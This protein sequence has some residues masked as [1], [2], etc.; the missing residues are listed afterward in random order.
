MATRIEKRV[1][2]L[3]RLS[4]RDGIGVAK[5]QRR[6]KKWKK[7]YDEILSERYDKLDDKRLL[8][9]ADRYKKTESKY[10]LYLEDYLKAKHEKEGV[11]K[12]DTQ[13]EIT[14]LSE[15]IEKLTNL[16]REQ[17]DTIT[18]P[19]IKKLILND[20][21]YL[22]KSLPKKIHNIS[23]LLK[24][25]SLWNEYIEREEA[26][27]IALLAIFDSIDL[28]L[29]V[30]A[31][32]NH[33]AKNTE[34]SLIR[35]TLSKKHDKSIF[36][37]NFIDDYF[38]N[39]TGIDDKRIT[40]K[41]VKSLE[42]YYT[43]PENKKIA[44]VSMMSS[45][46][47]KKRR[48][49]L[50]RT[51][52]FLGLQ[53]FAR[54]VLFTIGVVSLFVPFIQ[55]PALALI[56][57]SVGV[58]IFPVLTQFLIGKK[59][60]PDVDSNAEHFIEKSNE[61]IKIVEEGLKTELSK[62]DA[63][64]DNEL[65]IDSALDEKNEIKSTNTHDKP[66]DDTIEKPEKTKGI[67][68]SINRFLKSKL[69]SRAAYGIKKD[70]SNK[71]KWLSKNNEL[72]ESEYASLNDDS[73]L[74]II[75]D[76]KSLSSYYSEYYHSY[77]EAKISEENIDV[78]ID[79]QDNN[80]PQQV[81]INSNNQN[82]D[83]KEST[84]K[85]SLE[86]Q[87]I[88]HRLDEIKDP[89]V[90]KLIE[91]DLECLTNGLP[92]NVKDLR[93]LIENLSQWNEF[94]EREEAKDIAYLGIASLIELD[95]SVFATVKHEIKNTKV[96]LIRRI[97][98]KMSDKFLLLKK[99]HNLLNKSSKN[100]E[101][102]TIQ[103][104]DFL[105]SYYKNPDN[106]KSAILA[107]MATLNA[108]KEIKVL[109]RKGIFLALSKIVTPLLFV[110][111]I[112]AIFS[113]FPPLQIIGT[114]LTSIAVSRVFKI[115][116]I[117]LQFRIG[118]KVLPSV[119]H[120]IVQSSIKHREETKKLEETTEI[121]LDEIRGYSTKKLDGVCGC[122]LKQNLG[123]LEE[124]NDAKSNFDNALHEE[125]EKKSV[126]SQE[127]DSSAT[128]KVKKKSGFSQSSSLMTSMFGSGGTF[129]NMK[130]VDPDC[131]DSECVEVPD[132][133]EKLDSPSLTEALKQEKSE[134]IKQP[135]D[136]TK[137]IEEINDEEGK[138][139]RIKDGISLTSTSRARKI[140]VARL[141]DNHKR[142]L[143]KLRK[144]TPNFY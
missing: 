24:E 135:D 109:R 113:G 142:K 40:Q 37:K 107:R 13:E 64:E 39:N 3:K 22:K 43:V 15:K 32:V 140:R 128:E 87:D 10:T 55:L 132:N 53:K 72:L 2:K 41:I 45:Q 110:A 116:S 89:V 38:K 66:N 80:E 17:T 139:N 68:N 59:L 82:I 130:C 9:I 111:G 123:L 122:C 30:F 112:A 58:G 138:K 98:E 97:L 118:K 35:R 106:K 49:R 103:F 105:E 19:V 90:K 67:F 8:E 33:E 62:K 136:S 65:I 47:A 121:N 124:T 88:Q 63:D 92:E 84:E 74:K 11:D 21:T 93:I 1:N 14:E 76:Y 56:G 131:E 115:P 60:L 134:A 119:D 96:S 48:K 31:S 117:F 144:R 101:N 23:E 81:E 71:E 7:E 4:T 70:N 114:G 25:L 143:K 86:N 6:Q 36:L 5:D 85:I 108:R 52:W 73:C 29:S 127:T 16:L 137:K 141:K 50:L 61:E 95:L 54:P 57:I 18:N 129:F 26:L 83:F 20:L 126:S 44:L 120:S 42:D 133:N 28:E 51:S 46:D 99:K 34:V 102:S 12:T 27:Y 94:N 77:L 100:S 75:E 69:A 104:I 78:E 79:E 125:E 91:D